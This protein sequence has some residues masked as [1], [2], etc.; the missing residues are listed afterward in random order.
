MF[1][2]KSTHETEKINAL[3]LI[4]KQIN[5]FRFYLYCINY[6]EL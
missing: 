2:Q 6:L 1:N 3:C 5:D 4:T